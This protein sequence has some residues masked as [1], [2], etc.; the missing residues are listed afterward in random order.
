M[1]ELTMS[2]IFLNDVSLHNGHNLVFDNLFLFEFIL[3]PY[4][5]AL[6]ISCNRI[7]INKSW[8]RDKEIYEFLKDVEKNN[9]RLIKG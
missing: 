7:E 1:S 8:N 2:D 4:K 9:A 3:M 5:L 6:D